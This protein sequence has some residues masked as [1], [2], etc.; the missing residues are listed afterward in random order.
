[1][2]KNRSN[3]TSN[4]EI[5]NI[6]LQQYRKSYIDEISN[7]LKD[8]RDNTLNLLDNTQKQNKQ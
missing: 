8:I 3:T 1:M 6:I 4:D 2:N 7:N 5:Y